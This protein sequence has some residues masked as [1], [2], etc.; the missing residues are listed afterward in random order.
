[1]SSSQRRSEL[2]ERAVVRGIALGEKAADPQGGESRII[3]STS[4]FPDVRA[5]TGTACQRKTRWTSSCVVPSDVLANDRQR[6]ARPVGCRPWTKEN[7]DLLVY[8]SPFS[9]SSSGSPGPTPTP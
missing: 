5:S 4:R 6:P 3:V 1:M 2:D 9:V 7:I 8:P